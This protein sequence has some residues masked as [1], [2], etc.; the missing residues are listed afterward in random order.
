MKHKT[1]IIGASSNPWRYSYK[2]AVMLK[3]HGHEV[4]AI[5]KRKSKID[6]IPIE[7]E[8]SE[9]IDIHTVTIYI[10]K[11]H[12]PE[13]YEYLLSLIKPLRMIFNPGTENEELEILARDSGIEVVHHCTL[14]MLSAGIY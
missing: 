11:T 9:N 13:Y 10:N 2:A 3:K 4:V 1:L 14:V 12:Q 8:L 7:T 6:E 5:G